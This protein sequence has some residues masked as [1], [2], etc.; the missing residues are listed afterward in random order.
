MAT[1]ESTPG[2]AAEEPASAAGPEAF[3]REFEELG[4][5]SYE[6][7]VLLAL[8]RLGSANTLQLARLSGVPR[9]SIYQ[10]LDELSTK[11]VAERVPGDGPAVWASPG[12][13][14]VLS[15]LDELVEE[16]LR[17]H[18][19]RTARLRDTLANAF[20]DKPSVALPYVHI[21]H[22]VDRTKAAYDR[23]LGEAETEILV[24]NRPPYSWVPGHVNT[25]VLDALERKVRARVL[26]RAAEWEDPDAEAFRREMEIYHRAGVEGRVVDELPVK[27]AVF[28]KKV[29]LTAMTDPVVP[30]VGYPTSLLIEHPGFAAVQADAFDHRWERARPL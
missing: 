5:S 16:R 17:A 15:R 23:L 24:V 14:E 18:R 9:T 29:A 28:D 26:Y 2:W 25:A 4:L 21:I 1:S 20:P 30:Q 13:E 22:G 27:L 10:V 19:A 11:R 6:A 8:M 7:R 12:H 3:R